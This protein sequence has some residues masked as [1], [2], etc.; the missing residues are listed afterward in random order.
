MIGSCAFSPRLVLVGKMKRQ[1]KECKTLNGFPPPRR[2]P[3]DSNSVLEVH[4][5]FDLALEHMKSEVRVPAETRKFC[6]GKGS[7][8]VQHVHRVTVSSVSEIGAVLPTV[9]EKKEKNRRA[10][11][12]DRQSPE[13]RRRTSE[14][15]SIPYPSQH[16]SGPSTIIPQTPCTA[17]HA[18]LHTGPLPI[19]KVSLT[20]R[21]YS[22]SGRKLW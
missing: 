21:V 1:K 14:I 22:P 15:V 20:F 12:A 2:T 5:L 16:R 13:T 3:T 18:H 8:G 4:S 11:G 17:L 7:I 19:N 10:A 6:N 9:H